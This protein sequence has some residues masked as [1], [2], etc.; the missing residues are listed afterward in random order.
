[1]TPL[2][3]AGKELFERHLERYAPADPYYE[4]YTDKKG[5]QRR[6]RRAVPPGLS[7]RDAKI[8]KSV[9]RRAHY[10]DKG[11][12]ICGFRF[13]WTFIIGVVPGAGDIAAATLNY[14]LVVRKAKKAEIPGWLLSRMLM[15]NAVSAG[16]GIVPFMGDVFTAIYKTNSRNAALLEEFLRIRGEELIKLNAAGQD[17]EAAANPSTSTSKKNGKKVIAKGVTKGDAEQVK[18]GSGMGK[19]DTVPGG[20][21]PVVQDQAV[22]SESGAAL[23]S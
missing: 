20:L 6:R 13:G 5:K 11:F 12:S 8:L 7:T 1:R 2:G 22:G 23:N 14:V 9:Q 19:G 16:V 21:T 17:V 3:K 4:D 10:L 18:P 15:N